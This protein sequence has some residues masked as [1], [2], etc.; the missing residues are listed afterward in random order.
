MSKGN[1]N[2]FRYLNL[3]GMWSGFGWT[4]L[5]RQDDGSLTLATLPRLA[6]ALSDDTSASAKPAGGEG[7]AVN[8]RG[9]VFFT[10]ST[11]HSMWLIDPCDDS[12]RRVPCLGGQGS[13]PPHFQSPRDVLIHP[14]RQALVVVDTGNKRLQLFDLNSLQLLDVW[15]DAPGGDSIFNYPIAA[16]V[17]CQGRVVVVDAD[18]KTPRIH[19][20]DMRGKLLDSF[21]ADNRKG[22]TLVGPVGIDLLPQKNESHIFVLDSEQKAV[23]VF[24]HKGQFAATI[25]LSGAE[26]SDLLGLIVEDDAIYVGDNSRNRLLKFDRNGYLI[27]EAF[28]YKGPVAGL[29]RD[30][31][32][33]AWLSS[34]S[35]RRPLRFI[36]R[37]DGVAFVKEG[38]LFRPIDKPIVVSNEKVNWHRLQAEGEFGADGTHVQFR[39]LTADERTP[40]LLIKCRLEDLLCSAADDSVQII[41]RDVT[42]MI[43]GGGSRY[44]WLAIKFQG[45][46]TVSPRLQQL[47]LAFDHVTYTKHLP[48]AYQQRA[49]DPEQLDRLLSLFESFYVDVERTVDDID[50]H[51]DP[52][53]APDGLL[54]WLAGWLGLELSESWP[55]FKKRQAIRDAYEQSAWRGTPRG[56]RWA[57]RYFTGVD[58]H[59]EEPLNNAS[60]WMLSEEAAEASSESHGAALGFTTRLAGP[61]PQGAV[62]GASAVLDQSQ[63]IN[64][65]KLGTPLFSDLAHQFSVHLYESRSTTP[66][67][68]EAIRRV[69]ERESPAHTFYHICTVRPNMRVGFQAILGIDTVVGGCSGPPPLDELARGASGENLTG[70]MPSRVGEAYRVGQTARLNAN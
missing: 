60:F 63:L 12:I 1:I 47:R 2:N 16:A 6:Q 15:D 41:P 28:G 31:Q 40:A 57:A 68:L 33:G 51:F 7:V 53:A 3:D 20:F 9:R 54:D 59:I 26:K 19:R 37:G 5:E 42:D 32:G 27:G 29:A 46:G 58:V 17:D 10:H 34:G 49:P 8:Y 65:E 48:V 69:I 66:Q 35:G 55:N 70:Q 23:V 56:L 11:D 39:F 4:S 64:R 30:G 24:D 36:L 14:Q 61:H 18:A 21:P 22:G 67:K 38:C 45:D 25:P 13:R 43:V 52:F 44:L 50:R 62:V